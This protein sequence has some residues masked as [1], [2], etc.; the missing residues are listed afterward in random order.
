MQFRIPN[1]VGVSC[2]FGF[3]AG[4]GLAASENEVLSL[5]GNEHQIF[6]QNSKL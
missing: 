3:T 4:L 1:D 6:T 5:L 2:V